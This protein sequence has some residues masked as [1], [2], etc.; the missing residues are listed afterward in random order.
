M[1]GFPLPDWIGKIHGPPILPEI[2]TLALPCG[3]LS[4]VS[5]FLAESTLRT[6]VRYYYDID[7][8]LRGALEAL[9]G[10][11]ALG[12]RLGSSVGNLLQADFQSWEC[13][14]G[15]ISG[16]PCPPFS[17]IGA[18]RREDDI[19]WQ[20]SFFFIIEMVPAHD[21]RSPGSTKT[22]YSKWIEHLVSAAPMW[23]LQSWHL[24][25]SQFL[26]PQ[27]RTRLYTVGVNAMHTREL[28]REPRLLSAGPA[29]TF[30]DVLH[31]GI[32][33]FQ[34]DTLST[35]LKVNLLMY[36]HILQE[37]RVSLACLSLDRDPRA[38]F[39]PY[40]RT[41]G[42]IPTLRTANHPICSA[43]S[44]LTTYIYKLLEKCGPSKCLE[45]LLRGNCVGENLALR[46]FE[47]FLLVLAAAGRAQR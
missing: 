41:D 17:A 45:G 15:T 35:H 19:R 21:E 30:L 14:T 43:P 31:P 29:R 46:F 1:E 18:R 12:F 40:F 20:G 23:R 24:D 13:V 26:C 2:V 28:P 44:W 7:A 37:H 5:Q 10:N 27:H 8:S 11:D 22:C 39:G 32:E 38:D 16:P 4:G 42:L 33:P 25:S 9:H 34:E 36:K 6:E 3:G 47:V